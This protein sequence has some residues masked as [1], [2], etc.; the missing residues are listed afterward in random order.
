MAEKNWSVD[1]KK[2]LDAR[3]VSLVVS[4]AAGSGKT[5]VLTERILSLVK[6]KNGV[7]LAR[8]CVVTFTKAAAAE[9][10]ARL[11]RKLSSAID[12]ET[13]PAAARRLHEA[14]LRLNRAQISTI[15]SF[16]LKLLR[17]YASHLKLGANLSLCAEDAAEE[18]KRAAAEE[19]LEAYLTS[20]G[21]E[22]QKDRFYRLFCPKDDKDLIKILIKME[23][24]C[25]CL[26]EGSAFFR[27]RLDRLREALSEKDVLST[28]AGNALLGAWRDLITQFR[29]AMRFLEK[30]CLFS[31]YTAD[32]A[33]YFAS[34]A[35][36]C[37]AARDLL[38]K[39]D[40]SGI[41]EALTRGVKRQLQF[42]EEKTASPEEL[43]LGKAIRATRDATGDAFK[44][45]KQRL[46]L[47]PDE[48]WLE[49]KEQAE[50][51]EELLAVFEISH[52]LFREKKREKGLLTFSD[53]Q[54][55]TLSLV[56]EKKDGVF[57]PTAIA[58]EIQKDYDAI[59]V[60][61]YQDTNRVQDLIFR[62]VSRPDNLFIVGDPKQSIYRFRAAE[63]E[64][65]TA[66]KNNAPDYRPGMKEKFARILLSDN[67]RSDPSVIDLTN[68]VFD[69][70]MGGEAPDALY[71]EGDRLVCRKERP[72]NAVD[73]AAEFVLIRKSAASERAD[74]KDESREEAKWICD[75]IASILNGEIRRADGTLYAPGDIAVLVRKWTHAYDVAEGLRRRGVPVFLA[76]GTPETE[77]PEFLF[78]TSLLRVTENPSDD[79]DLIAV[80]S[81]PV[82]RFTPDDLY[83]IRR[84]APGAPFFEALSRGREEASESREK[85]R[86]FF[87]A[88]E[89]MQ[90]AARTLSPAAYLFYLYDRFQIDALYYEENAQSVK[91]TLFSLAFG[92]GVPENLTAAG[93]ASY[94]EA[95]K[96]EKPDPAIEGGGVKLMTIHASKGA[97]FP[98]VFLAL[99]GSE[100]GGQSDPFLIHSEFGVCFK[101]PGGAR[102]SIRYKPA[103][104]RLAE[105]LDE[106]KQTEELKR[107]IYVGMTRAKEKL[108][109]SA[110]PS[111]A[112]LNRAFAGN[113]TPIPDDLARRSMTTALSILLYSLQKCGAF[114]E[115]VR[116]GAS[117]R[118]GLSEF[119]FIPVDPAAPCARY[120]ER[121]ILSGN[122][123][124]FFDEDL[125]RRA[126]AFSYENNGLDTL[127]KK[128]SVS[129]ILRQNREDEADL[130]ARSLLPLLTGTEPEDA[131]TRGTAMHEF[132]QFADF[133][134][135]FFS[136]SAEIE[137]LLQKGFLTPRK[138]A[139]LDQK[140][141][142]T[143]FSSPFYAMIRRSRET[144]HERRFNVLLPADELL[145]KP[146]KVLVQGVVDF[147][148]ENANGSLSLLDFKT[149]RV[150]TKDGEAV[151]R[152]RHGEQLR[153]YRKA[154]QEITGKP[155]SSLYLYSFSLG[156]E[157]E[158][159]IE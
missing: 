45:A 148:F 93:L 115:A 158:V 2:A 132:M 11:Y 145:G 127:P 134:K 36:A 78:V 125:F 6:E 42:G 135:A 14:M 41:E 18:F 139:L 103:L 98:I 5:E 52:R 116:Y 143:F 3:G 13:D 89:K 1:Q 85:C 141:L 37:D 35:V 108:I 122:E 124:I 30:D 73:H 138:A 17:E 155:V 10:Q 140:A 150:K 43:E 4:A 75:R 79:V 25:A 94:F 147:W 72:E 31:A 9:L 69:V 22:A 8:V 50:M 71:G 48:L 44:K 106:K 119:S 159:P 100:G 57:Q 77:R 90:H 126:M 107:L 130:K 68:T 120:I 34:R 92:D 102:D 26:P 58:R 83:R 99:L 81:S 38:E 97:Q 129:E 7:D 49:L 20:P 21:D 47:T 118:D 104:Y 66:Y 15:D 131:A 84:L 157:I 12:E 60:D 16:S 112:A 109:L 27:N 96:T 28:F 24:Y 91:K 80:L 144:V 117:R 64:I 19:A 55:L 33:D 53:L 23:D 67:F 54:T 39:G 63:P 153:L 88:F 62:C 76:K 152:R 111:M 56:A 136:V 87:E 113:R 121:S 110:T 59:F 82:F 114:R 46:F 142:E 137:R 86:E 51:T 29:D 70:A 151:L 101:L 74:E 32:G 40:L 128:L 154:V 146:G 105:R 65:F 95:A 133:N 61:E 156:K 149:D 123:K